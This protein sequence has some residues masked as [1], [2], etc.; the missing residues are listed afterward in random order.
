MRTWC[1]GSDSEPLRI[2]TRTYWSCESRPLPQPSLQLSSSSAASGRTLAHTSVDTQPTNPTSVHVA[3]HTA[4]P[5]PPLRLWVAHDWHSH[6]S[7]NRWGRSL[8]KP[9]DHDQGH[10]Q[11]NRGSGHL[12]RSLKAKCRESLHPKIPDSRLWNPPAPKGPHTQILGMRRGP[13][14]EPVILPPTPRRP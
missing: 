6:P 13:L 1:A 14:W 9:R 5:W 4:A 12:E 7:A 2:P 8:Y 10:R 11:E 3:P